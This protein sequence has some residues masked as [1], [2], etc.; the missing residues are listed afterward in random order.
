MPSIPERDKTNV[1]KTHARTIDL[2]RFLKKLRI[3]NRLRV[4]FEYLGGALAVGAVS[5]W[6]VPPLMSLLLAFS[7]YRLPDEHGEKLF[8]SFLQAVLPQ[9]LGCLL[10][11]GNLIYGNSQFDS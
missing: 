6:N 9:Q 8:V 2:A 10:L 7:W 4:A 1:T 3:R 5:E 11:S